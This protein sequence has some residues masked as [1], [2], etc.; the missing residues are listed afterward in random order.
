MEI[1]GRVPAVEKARLLITELLAKAAPSAI[2]QPPPTLS[3]SQQSNEGRKKFAGKRK[4]KSTMID[5]PI[6]SGQARLIIGKGGKNVQQLR[7]DNSGA[8]IYIEDHR[9]KIL[10]TP[11]AA[12]KA[13]NAILELIQSSPHASRTQAR[14]TN[15][16]ERSVKPITMAE[17][18]KVPVTKV[19]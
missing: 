14:R 13:K 5:L 15:Q 16:L 9:V 10:G 1:S 6:D 4:S 18:S 7:Q 17:L 19:F 2:H 8:R 12:E 3:T 11:T